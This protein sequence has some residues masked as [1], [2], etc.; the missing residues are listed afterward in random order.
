MPPS[1]SVTMCGWCSAARI[2]RSARKRRA[3]SGWPIGADINL[4][5]TCCVKSWSTRSARYTAPMPPAAI[6][7]TSVKAP[8]RCPH[9]DTSPASTTPAMLVGSERKVAARPCAAS[10]DSTSRRRSGRPAQAV[11]SVLATVSGSPPT[12]KE[13]RRSTSAQYSS[14]GAGGE[15]GTAMDRRA[16]L[17][18]DRVILIRRYAPHAGVASSLAAPP[19]PSCAG[20]GGGVNRGQGDRP[21]ESMDITRLLDRWSDGDENALSELLPLVYR[22]LRQ[23]ADHYLRRERKDHTLQPTALVHEAYLRLVDVHD[24]G[25]HNRSHFYGAAAQV[26][27]RILVDHA[28]SHR[29][30][31]RGH[32]VV[33]VDLDQALNV[34]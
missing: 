8:T 17:S 33:P 5:A 20:T 10:N 13:N 26:M 2:W 15:G 12:T 3:A 7:S 32:G 28:R 27:R 24:A 21:R 4:T 31:K 30:A 9:R 1:R 23:R 19:L 22:E 6:S 29:A 18:H 25:F 16:I 14:C 11:S 34:G